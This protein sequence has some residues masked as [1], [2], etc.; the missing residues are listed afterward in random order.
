MLVRSLVNSVLSC[1][2]IKTVGGCLGTVL[3]FF[4]QIMFLSNQ[5]FLFFNKTLAYHDQTQ[6]I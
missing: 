2:I 5:D 6:G 3:S 1:F 4:I